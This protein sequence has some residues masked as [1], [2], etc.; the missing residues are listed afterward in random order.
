[1]TGGPV[2]RP[3]LRALIA[4]L[5]L[6][7]AG[8]HDTDAVVEMNDK[9]T[10]TLALDVKYRAAFLE[11]ANDLAKGLP[12]FR[13]LQDA[14]TVLLKNPDADRRKEL[15]KAGL[16]ILALDSKNTATE[17]SS[18]FKVELQRLSA[19]EVLAGLRGGP[20]VTGDVPLGTGLH[21][22]MDALRLSRD[23][24]GIYTLEGMFPVRLSGSME[25]T[26]P[27]AAGIDVRA[28]GSKLLKSI[29]DFR[30]KVTM[31]VP[32]EVVDF[33]PPELGRRVAAKPGVKGAL[34]TVEFTIDADVG[35]RSGLVEGDKKGDYLPV[36]L[37]V[38]FR[39]PGGKSLPANA[40]WDGKAVPAAPPK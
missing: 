33:S 4:A 20:A 29:L 38:K 31:T 12:G 19:Q 32:G 13:V 26:A 35:P 15:E 17:L 24:D 22:P 16:K 3:P 14:E 28:L 1:M 11:P 8:C 9:G 7:A 10:T 30:A 23:R 18:N 34:R 25:G 21:L 40:L 5:A 39:M 27:P 36:P 37:R 6:A 2:P